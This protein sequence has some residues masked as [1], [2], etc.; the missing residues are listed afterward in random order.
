MVRSRTN[1]TERIDKRE[2]H[3]CVPA[4]ARTPQQAD[5]FATPFL[6]LVS[7]GAWVSHWVPHNQGMERVEH[8]TACIYREGT[9]YVALCPEL[10]IASQGD[11]IEDARHNLELAQDFPALLPD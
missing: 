8:V 2:R 4:S 10:D 1:P 6:G 3:S 7:S 5:L 9:A 11:T